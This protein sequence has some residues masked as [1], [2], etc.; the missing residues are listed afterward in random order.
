MKKEKSIFID[1]DEENINKLQI[2]N[3]KITMINSD[4]DTNFKIDLLKLL[5][6][7]NTKE[8]ELFTKFNPEKYR[9]LIIGYYWNSDKKIQDGKC[10]CKNKCNGKGSGIGDG[11][12]KKIT[13]SIFKSGSIIITGGRLIKQIEDAYKSINNILKQNYHD[14]M[15]LS[16]LDFI[17]EDETEEEN[18]VMNEKYIEEKKEIKN[19]KP[20]Y[21]DRKIVKIKKI[22]Y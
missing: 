22:N 14:I 3:Y 20:I 12:C 9:G 2:V 16:I 11:E 6:I 7:L 1:M 17:D 19:I 18:D 15:K 5:N 4:F 10:L 21:D 13:I 8:K